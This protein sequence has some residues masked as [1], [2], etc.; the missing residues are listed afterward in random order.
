M[1]S[2]S[3]Q[4][5]ICDLAEYY[6]I[7]DYRHLPVKLVATLASGLRGDSRIKLRL[8]GEQYEMDSV[9]LAMIC[10]RLAMVQHGLFNTGEKPHLV[11]EAMFGIESEDAE[12]VTR[13][14][15]DQF[16]SPEA[17]HARYAELT[18]EKES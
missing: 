2:A 16:D 3:E 11:T 7:F 15:P 8:K 17:F 6:H 9:L 4:D 14:L 13:I 10:D 18:K 5:L 12:D 1:I